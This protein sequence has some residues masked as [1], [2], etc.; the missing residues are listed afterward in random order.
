MPDLVLYP[1]VVPKDSSQWKGGGSGTY[2][3]WSEPDSARTIQYC[4]L[5]PCTNVCV[6]SANMF[7]SAAAEPCQ[8]RPKSTALYP[9]TVRVSHPTTMFYVGTVSPSLS[10]RFSSICLSTEPQSRRVHETIRLRRRRLR[11]LLPILSNRSEAG[12]LDH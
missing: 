12:R 7:L 4:I 6:L 2:R 1:G 10:C 8:N 11:N 9:P 5:N 3:F